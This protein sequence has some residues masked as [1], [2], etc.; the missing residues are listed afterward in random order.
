MQE[1]SSAKEKLAQSQTRNMNKK[2]KHRDEKIVILNDQVDQSEQKLDGVKKELQQKS[3]E[4]NDLLEMCCDQK[5]DLRKTNEKLVNMSGEKIALQK[6]MSRL[7]QKLRLTISKETQDEK[8]V[9]YEQEIY[10]LKEEVRE[11]EKVVELLES[12]TSRPL[13][14]DDST[15]RYVNVV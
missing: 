11:L 5:E 10:D 3:V 4:V 13:K 2:I 8:L 9:Q 14:M 12:D 15:T 1:L 7:R 6:K